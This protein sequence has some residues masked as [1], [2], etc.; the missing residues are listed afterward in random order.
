L[1]AQ[2]PKIDGYE[3]C[4]SVKSDPAMSCIKVLIISGMTQGSDWHK[5]REVGADAYITKPFSSIELAERVEELLR[6]S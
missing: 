1:D 2:L 3:V 6:N 4:K 5:A